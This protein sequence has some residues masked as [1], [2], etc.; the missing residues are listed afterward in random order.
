MFIPHGEIL[1]GLQRKKKRFHPSMQQ[2][3]GTRQSLPSYEEDR[4]QLLNMSTS[5][6]LYINLDKY[7]FYLEGHDWNKD[8]KKIEDKKIE[9]PTFCFWIFLINSVMKRSTSIL[10]S[11]VRF[12][13]NSADDRSLWL[14]RKFTRN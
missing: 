9:I 3:V 13:K 4:W 7:V 12:Q 2:N 11:L 10:I 8:K 1:C 14:K 5:T 6:S